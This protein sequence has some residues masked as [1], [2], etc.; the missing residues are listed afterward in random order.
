MR[1]LI[2]IAG[3]SGAGKTTISE[4]LLEKFCIPRV[5]T[6]TTRPKRPEEIVNQS[7]HFETNTSFEKLHF[8]EHTRYGSYQYG[9]SRE[10]LDKAW[11]KSE[12][13]SLIV[14]ISGVEAYINAI[15]GQVYFLY[16]T[17]STKK[18]LQQR[19]LR[20]GD[21]LAKIKERLSG[22]ELNPLPQNLQKD[23]HILVNDNWIETERR[24]TAIIRHL[25]G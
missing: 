13:V 24:L 21:N 1:K 4:Y 11:E 6:H 10:A 7:Y 12:L 22:S 15:R 19:L 17:A 8:F 20:R 18:E 16:V 9:S 2:L 5:V 23:A 3:P 14:D 25:Q